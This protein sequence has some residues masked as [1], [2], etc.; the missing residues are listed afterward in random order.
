MWQLGGSVA[1]DAALVD[2]KHTW[3]IKALSIFF[4][5]WELLRNADTARRKDKQPHV[6]LII[7]RLMVL[8]ELSPIEQNSN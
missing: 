7:I 2:Y 3:L 5:F 1:N 8:S 6:D 4:F